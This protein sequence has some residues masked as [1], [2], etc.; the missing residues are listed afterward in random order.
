MI[1]LCQTDTTAGFC[2]KDLKKINKIKNRD[3]NLP[4]LITLIS[5][6]L[7]KKN[8]RIPLNFRNFIR[9]SKKSTFIYPNKKSFRVIK[10][11]R[12]A[13]FLKSIGGWAYSSSANLHGAKFDINFAKSV[14]DV[15]VD[16]DLFEDKPSNIYKLS[17]SN[18]KKIR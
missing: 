5:F 9:R 17:N 16:E 7:L 8:T 15:V 11:K 1:Y 4:C 18:M 13:T 12:H 2:S 6:S 14:A 3:E 10:D